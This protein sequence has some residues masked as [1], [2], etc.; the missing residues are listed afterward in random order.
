MRRRKKYWR[1]ARNKKYKKRNRCLEI[2]KREME[3]KSG[4]P[5]NITQKSYFMKQFQGQAEKSKIS[6]TENEETNT[7]TEGQD[8][9]AREE[10]EEHISNLKKKKAAEED[11][12]RNKALIWAKENIREKITHIINRIYKKE[13]KCRITAEKDCYN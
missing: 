4:I 9:I 7:N 2:Y 3:M 13:K 1:M 8:N 10:K 6:Q 12:I 5:K 11:N